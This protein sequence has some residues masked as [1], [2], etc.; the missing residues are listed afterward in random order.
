MEKTI[1][2]HVKYGPSFREISSMPYPKIKQDPE[3]CS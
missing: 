1:G 3:L 2:Y